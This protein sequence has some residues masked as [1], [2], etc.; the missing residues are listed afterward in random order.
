MAVSILERPALPIYNNAGNPFACAFTRTADKVLVGKNTGTHGLV[1]GQWVYVKCPIEDYNGHWLVNT[2]G[3]TTTFLL[4]TRDDTLEQDYIQDTTGYYYVSEASIDASPTV[5]NNFIHW[6]CIHLPIIYR[7][8]NTLWPI[9]SVDTVRTISTVTDASGY[10][11]LVVSA[12]IKASGSAAALTYVK[13]SGA[14]DDTLNGVWQI[15]SYTNDTTFTLAIPYSTANDTALT[16]A[17]IQY[18]Y[19]NY[20]FKIK[21][22]AGLNTS[23]TFV[24]EKPY[25]LMATL[26]IIPDEDGLCAFSIN[27][28][29]KS[30][31]SLKNNLLLGTLP[32][33]LD[34]FTEFYIETAESYDS[35]DGTT[36]STTTSSYTSD[37]SSFEGLAVNAKLPFK[38]IYSGILSEYASG[39]DDQKFLTAFDRPTIFSGEYF[40]LSFIFDN[41][42]SIQFIDNAFASSLASWTTINDAGKADWSF[43][44]GNAVASGAVSGTDYI[45]QLRS[46]A[47]GWPPGDYSITI[48]ATNTSTGGVAPLNSYVEIWGSNISTAIESSIVPNEIT[49]FWAVGAGSVART[50][51]F[52]LDKYYKYIFF[53][54]FKAGPTGGYNVNI[55]VAS[56]VINSGPGFESSFPIILQG[57]DYTE[58][59]DLDSGVYRAELTD[60]NCASS[61]FNVVVYKAQNYGFLG[62]GL[63]TAISGAW[64]TATLSTFTFNGAAYPYFLP[65]YYMPLVLATNNRVSFSVT[66]VITGTYTGI[67]SLDF[68]LTD[69]ANAAVSNVSTLNLTVAG[70]SQASNAVLVTTNAATR[71][72]IGLGSTLGTGN[73]AITIVLSAAYSIT[74]LSSPITET[75]TIDINC[76]CDQPSQEPI[77]L[78]W[79]N[80]LGGFDYWKFTSFKDL[81]IDITETGD[82]TNNVFPEWPNSYGE[83]ADTISKETHRTSREQILVRSQNL[84][85]DQVDAIARIKS[86]PL[87]QIVNSIY[88]RRTVKLDTDSFVKRR[89]EDKLYTISFTITYT[90]DVPSQTV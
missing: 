87:V 84:T 4:I 81:I 23:H 39:D 56:I 76:D 9:N 52:T 46:I 73:V 77:Y 80:N 37:Q 70:G 51:T 8:S 90:D 55:S 35:S 20:T 71:L 31:V 50:L 29:I 75:K 21:V 18:Y 25:E 54:F 13:V 34:A 63:W 47:G 27:E 53:D 59:D 43:S 7:L 19:N 17:S 3:S 64:N 67:I 65:V 40:D 6:N 15:T 62:A 82:A 26:D 22:Y 5:Y 88:D 86:S 11:A 38:N 89:E 12:D 79:L 74:D 58:M 85:A 61:S 33:N 1:D 24:D 2:Q 49:G 45:G 36:L 72:Q 68:S 57:S 42:A 41:A 30:K 32:N 44:G 60:P 10:C 16:G 69:N 66:A 14:S 78:S 28:L 48:T 83:F